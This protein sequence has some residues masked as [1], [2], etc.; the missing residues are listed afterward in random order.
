M[1]EEMDVKPT[2]ETEGTADCILDQNNIKLSLN[3]SV[4]DSSEA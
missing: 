4:T 3:A 1:N 2:D